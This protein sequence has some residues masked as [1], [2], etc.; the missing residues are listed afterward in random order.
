MNALVVKLNFLFI[1]SININK[2]YKT[3]ITA[4]YVT[5]KPENYFVIIILLMSIVKIAMNT[6]EKQPT[7]SC[8]DCEEN[9][10]LNELYD[11]PWNCERKQEKVGLQKDMDAPNQTGQGNAKDSE[12]YQWW[13]KIR[14]LP[15]SRRNRALTRRCRECGK[16]SF[17]KVRTKFAEGDIELICDECN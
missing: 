7:A 4:I 2:C 9:F 1:L 13:S 8:V 12:W 3:E 14:E 6:C 5:K 11:D 10:T 17:Q 16:G 15:D